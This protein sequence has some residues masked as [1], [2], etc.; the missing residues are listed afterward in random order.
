MY[1]YHALINALSAH[2]VHTNLNMIFYT[3]VEHCSTQSTIRKDKHP[4][5]THPNTKTP[6]WIQMCTT[7][8]CVVHH[9]CAHT[10]THNDC[11]RNCVL[12]LV[13]AKILWEEEG[14]QF[15]FKR[16]Q[17][18]AV[19]EVKSLKRNCLATHCEPITL[20]ARIPE[21]NHF[22]FNC[23]NMGKNYRNK[24]YYNR[25]TDTPEC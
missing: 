12:I 8:I 19:S 23:L 5:P 15:G 13:G 14:F 7:L 24:L 17:G 21:I 22:L 1:I 18:W 11:S 2:M 10:H 6:Q 4:P 3:H 20:C 9:T 16:W 25:T